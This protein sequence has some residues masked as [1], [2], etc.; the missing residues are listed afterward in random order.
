MGLFH[1]TLGG[2][3]DHPDLNVPEGF[4]EAISGAYDADLATAGSSAEA[5]V[6]DL[7]AQ[8]DAALAQVQALK[9]ENYDM[10]VSMGSS[11]EVAEAE[12]NENL[13]GAAATNAEGPEDAG[14]ES[15]FEP[16][17]D[18]EENK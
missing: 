16:V 17:T 7:T 13:P 15:L 11:T 4:G 14:I 18:D 1:D 2:L 8:L 6:L 12:A 3:D 10:L 9:V 5:K